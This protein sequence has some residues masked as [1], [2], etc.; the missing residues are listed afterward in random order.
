M[1]SSRALQAEER[2]RLREEH[3]QAVARESDNFTT[4][5]A[6]AYLRRGRS[7]IGSLVK[8]EGLP[9]RVISRGPKGRTRYLFKRAEIEVW[10]SQRMEAQIRRTLDGE[11]FARRRAE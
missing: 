3:L 8:L 7:T 4:A 11:R 5:E 1:K 6:A 9:A 2:R 10:L